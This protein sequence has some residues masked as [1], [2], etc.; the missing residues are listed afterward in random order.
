MNRAN[1]TY[2]DRPLVTTA[3]QTQNDHLMLGYV[4]DCQRLVAGGTTHPDVVFGPAHPNIRRLM[5]SRWDLAAAIQQHLS[6]PPTP[7]PRPHP[8]VGLATTVF[9]NDNMVSGLERLGCF[10]VFQRL[11]AWL[12]RPTQE[13][14][15]ALGVDHAPL[16]S[17]Q[18]V[19][20]EQW[21]DFL[22]W[23]Q[24]RDVVIQRPEYATAEFRHMYNSSLRLL[25]WLGGFAHACSVDQ[26]GAI[27]L[28]E[29][30][31]RHVLHIGNWALDGAFFQCY[32]GLGGVVPM[33]ARR[34][35]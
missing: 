30:F 3:P 10:V 22:L 15:A 17:Q 11:V 20:H 9:D 32:P 28:T 2:C 4:Q 35:S 16:P 19:P 23:G 5:E 27:Y 7:P 24:L 34:G 1:A 26:A 6:L 12:I 13:T 33:Q 21:V 29:P 25:N 14:F 31:V 18:A 8:L